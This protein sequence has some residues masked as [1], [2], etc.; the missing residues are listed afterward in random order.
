M[1]LLLI[2]S[3]SI[4]FG[5]QGR[6][7]LVFK[8][9]EEGKHMQILGIDSWGCSEY[10]VMYGCPVAHLTGFWF[11]NIFGYFALLFC[12]SC[13]SFND[14]LPRF[15]H[16][17]RPVQ[18]ASSTS[19]SKLH[20]RHSLALFYYCNFWPIFRNLVCDIRSN[21]GNY[22]TLSFMLLWRHLADFRFWQL[23]H[24]R[25]FSSST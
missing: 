12:F 14:L 20:W 16:P 23:N 9:R 25:R 1:N 22:C 3:S 17:P 10:E 2:G 18:S 24:L 4:G 21:R 13:K 15:W 19:L 8:V 6:F 11:S 5:F 7:S